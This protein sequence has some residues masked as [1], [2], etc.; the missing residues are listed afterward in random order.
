MFTPKQRQL[1]PKVVLILILGAP[2]ILNGQIQH[3]VLD[4]GHGGKDPGAVAFNT[5]EKDVALSVT[6]K[7]GKLIE[8]HLS[9]VDVSYTRETDKFVELFQR[10]RIAN[11][12][13]ADFFISI[14]ANAASS[15][16]AR[17][18]ETF[19]LGLHRNNANLEVVRRENA[20][21]SL[22]GGYEQEYVDITSPEAQILLE[23]HQ[24]NYLDQSIQLA[25]L[26]ENRFTNHAGLKSRG[27]KQAGFLVLYKTSMPSVLIELG[28]LTHREECVFL[29]SETGQNI[30]AESIFFAFRDFV[31][32]NTA[33]N[34]GPA[35]EHNATN[36]IEEVV[37][38]PSGDSGTTYKVQLFA[39]GKELP[40]DHE[41]Y[42][43]FSSI[44]M[45]PVGTL[46]RILTENT[47]SK[48]EALRWI[49][50]AKAAGYE[51]AY[52]V[53][54]LNGIRQ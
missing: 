54:Y 18:T 33:N 10:A 43:V 49:G 12:S 32:K 44:T 16:S 22:E 26:I 24:Q 8:K 53:T 25:G 40:N 23:L 19:V 46:S 20:V 51:D 45:E 4:A 39:T 31:E 21:I 30:L 47:S 7:V 52:L 6:L 28:F 14:H 36:E 50:K 38:T 34:D 11:D 29:A 48:A 15:E 42:S 9:T 35:I 27:V 37:N 2:F 41:I 17:G 5:Q 13:G 3:V 1:I